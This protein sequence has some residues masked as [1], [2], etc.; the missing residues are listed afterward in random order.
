MPKFSPK[1]L[2]GA[3]IGMVLGDAWIGYTTRSKN[4]RITITHSIK[5]KEYLEYK[6]RILSDIRDFSYYIKDRKRFITLRQKVYGLTE[7]ISRNHSFLKHIQKSM[8]KSGTKTVTLYQLKRLNPLGLSLWYMD[9]GCVN[10]RKVNGKTKHR[11]IKLCTQCFTLEEIEII[12]QY[13][14]ECHDIDAKH[15]L[16]KGKPVIYMTGKSMMKFLK[17]T[18]PFSIPSMYYKWELKYD[19][20]PE[21]YLEVV[22]LLGVNNLATKAEHV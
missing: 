15:F 10:V 21:E 20:P 19:I 11:Y 8:Y 18:A 5:Q 12:K 7:L 16:E 9:D 13:F 17:I 14:K 2:R 4:A 3:L 1:E 22:R 6:G